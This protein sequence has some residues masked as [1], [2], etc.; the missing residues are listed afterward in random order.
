[1]LYLSWCKI[2]FSPLFFFDLF[3]L[4]GSIRRQKWIYFY[5]SIKIT[6]KLTFFVSFYKWEIKSACLNRG[7]FW[8][9]FRYISDWNIFLFRHAL[10]VFWKKNGLKTSCFLLKMQKWWE[11][12]VFTMSN[13]HILWIDIEP[14][15]MYVFTESDV[16]LHLF[17]ITFLVINTALYIY[18]ILYFH[19]YFS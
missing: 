13:V 4:T 16:G 5:N 1:M 3:T 9:I 2:Y 6:Q 17:Y 18:K 8:S 11:N 15:K 14:F 7:I 19:E 12:V 10:Y